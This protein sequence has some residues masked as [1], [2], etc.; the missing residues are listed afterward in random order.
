[1]TDFMSPALSLLAPFTV[2]AYFSQR[3]PC[4]TV[5]FF[6]VRITKGE[7][8]DDANGGGDAQEGLDLFLVINTHEYGS[9]AKTLCG[10]HQ[11]L[12]GN[13]RVHEIIIL[14]P[15]LAGIVRI[16]AK[17][18]DQRRFR[19]GLFRGIGLITL[20]REERFNV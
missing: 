14:A 17:H 1:M 12:G 10:K 16:G 15:K 6:F 18:D 20:G 5:L 19:Q 2:K 7:K 3:L 11:V 13:A 8:A 4:R 9:Q